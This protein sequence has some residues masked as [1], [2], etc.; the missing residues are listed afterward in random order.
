MLRERRTSSSLLESDVTRSVRVQAFRCWAEQKSDELQ[1]VLDSRL[2]KL[3]NDTPPAVL[4]FDGGLGTLYEALLPFSLRYMR[5]GAVQVANRGW[6]SRCELEGLTAVE[7]SRLLKR[8]VGSQL[9]RRLGDVGSDDLWRRLQS[10]VTDRCIVDRW[11]VDEQGDRRV[12]GAHYTPASIADTVVAQVL[13]PLVSGIGSSNVSRLKVVDPACGAGVFLVA[14]ARYLAKQ[15]EAGHAPLSLRD[16][17]EHCLFAVDRDPLAL[18]IAACELH[19]ATGARAEQLAHQLFVGDAVLTRHTPF[20]EPPREQEKRGNAG[21]IWKSNI[22]DI[23]SDRGGFDAV[24]GNPPWVA[25]VGRAAQPL[26]SKQLQSYKSYDCFTGYRTLHGVFIEQSSLLL[27]PGGRLGLILPTSVSDLQG[28]AGTR[29]AHNLRCKVDKKLPD[30]GAHAFQGVFQPSM[31]LLSTRQSGTNP[32][33][34]WRIDRKD[35]QPWEERLLERLGRAPKFSKQSFGERG[36]QTSAVDLTHIRQADTPLKDEDV[37]LRTGADVIEGELRPPVWCV[38]PSELR[39][40]FRPKHEWQAVR[41]LV[42]QTARYPIACLSDGN[43]FRNSI[44]AA[45]EHDPSSLVLY[46]NCSLVRWFHYQSQ[47]DARQGMPQVKVGHLRA[48]PAIPGLE[49]DT[50]LSLQALAATY[51]G[52]GLHEALRKSVDLLVASHFQLSDRERRGV[53]QWS[54]THR[55]PIPR[56]RN[57]LDR[58]QKDRRSAPRPNKTKP[59]DRA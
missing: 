8:R 19:T 49:S 57:D 46:L 6:V 42:R 10:H 30:L 25:Y 21:F 32:D 41:V 5:A 36:Y 7:R 48:L 40:N 39:G 17:A 56:P 35:L 13:S 14:A 51:E 11:V 20:E 1:H 54:A 16:V 15:S 52:N 45:F 9:L 4:S 2:P 34:Q 43:A 22:A 29:R 58:S 44:L 18:A 26:N 28:Y 23:F 55:P 37:Y 38:R 12:R 27:R 59:G 31:V 33:A 24:V 47:R 53:E 3:G 50:G